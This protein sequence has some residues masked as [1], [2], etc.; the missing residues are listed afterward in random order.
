MKHTHH[1]AAGVIADVCTNVHKTLSVYTF[2]T[3]RIY[4]HVVAYI[5]SRRR[6]RTRSPESAQS[7]ARECAVAGP[8]V[9]THRP[10]SAHSQ[11]I[12]FIHTSSMV[13]FH[14]FILS[15][16]HYFYK[17]LQV[18]KNRHH[19]PNCIMH[20]GVTY[21]RTGVKH[22]YTKHSVISKALGKKRKGRGDAG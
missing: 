11:N 1:N 18:R 5:R 17:V 20:E 16:I 7:Q 21:R 10:E 2:M 13:C 6:V 8:R 19:L 15:F 4:L 9:R 12:A 3:S 14:S 22:V